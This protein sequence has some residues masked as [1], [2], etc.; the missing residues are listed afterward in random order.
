[1]DL[2]RLEAIRSHLERTGGLRNPLRTQRIYGGPLRADS[3]TRGLFRD[4]SWDY[5]DPSVLFVLVPT[6]ILY[7]A[8]L[9]RVSRRV[10][11]LGENPRPL[12]V[13]GGVGLIIAVC[14]LGTAMRL[15]DSNE[16]Y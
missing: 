7:L 15:V 1:M 5:D 2:S 13:T 9:G 6:A 8:I 12:W 16:S 3:T 11:A 10:I 4:C 14:A